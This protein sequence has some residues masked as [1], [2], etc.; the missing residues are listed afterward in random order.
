MAVATENSFHG[1][2]V[3]NVK[4]LVFQKHMIVLPVT[5]ECLDPGTIWIQSGVEHIDEVSVINLFFWW[6]CHQ[7]SIKWSKKDNGGI[8]CLFAY[9]DTFMVPEW[10][11]DAI[12]RCDLLTGA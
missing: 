8:Q 4:K 2:L 11:F 7:M 3:N 1:S 10:F 6:I 9:A 12:L 5:V